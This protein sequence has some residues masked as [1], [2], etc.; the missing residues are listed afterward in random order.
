ME[1]VNSA[2][3]KLKESGIRRL[4]IF[5]FLLFTFKFTTLSYGDEV[6][7]PN[8]AGQFYPG[9]PKE[10]S[11]QVDTFLEAANPEALK[12]EVFAL[13]SPH[14]GYGYSGQVAAFGY[15]LIKNF[16]YKTVVILAPSHSYAFA[17]ASVYPAGSF[18]T[19][20]G[21]LAVDSEF[22]GKLMNRDK[23]IYFEP[24]AFAREHAV[25]VELPFLQKALKDFKIVPIV[26][27]DSTLSLCQRL[28][29]MLKEAI[30]A[31]KDVLVIVSSDLYHGYDYDEAEAFDKL[32]LGV[33][34]NMDAEGLYYGLREGRLQMCGG[35]P[36]VTALILAKAL[37]HDK[38]KLL[39]HTNS[40]QVTGNKIKGIWTVGYASC[41]I[42][43]EEGM[44]NKMQKRRLLEIARDSID[45][46]L[47]TGKKLEVVESDPV[48]N[49]NMGA[50]VTLHERG[51][52]RGCIG[53]LSGTEPLYL[54]VRDMAVEAATGDPRFP[55]V[56][57]EE[58]KDIDIEI[59]ALSELKRVGSADE[60]QLGI[61]GVL[62]RKG[63]NSGVFL[64]Q[65]ATETGWSKEEFMSYLCAQKA[66]LSPDAW[67]DKATEIYVFTAEVFSGRD[68]D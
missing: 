8:V 6:K 3:R 62:V 49:R 30:G 9:D 19:P 65:V 29:G 12:G 42:D 51:E 37:G 11:L 38:V 22:A 17:G 21:D 26:M 58:V 28:A 46:Y 7:Q 44:L 67:K 33:V 39:E 36:M 50:F 18:R 54:T 57:P 35:F 10:L 25:E 52:L 43:K 66:G 15:K 34:N 61:H 53:N 47:K 32:T 4:A 41:A 56:R 40:A 55:P 14:A 48:L 45:N 13:L 16:P 27:G 64:P 24:L 63:F 31:R 59:S 23:E 60:V 68:L 20:L 1:N 2:E 5:T